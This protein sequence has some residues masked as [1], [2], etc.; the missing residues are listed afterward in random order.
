MS[1][2]CVMPV[3]DERVIG[4]NSKLVDLLERFKQ[5]LCAIRVC[6]LLSSDVRGCSV[7]RWSYSSPGV[8]CS[9][10]PQCILQ[11]G[12]DARRVG[13]EDNLGVPIKLYRTWFQPVE[14][15]LDVRKLIGLPGSKVLLFLATSVSTG[16]SPHEA[17]FVLS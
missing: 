5:F 15:L 17:P 1:F 10:V 4:R 8:N 6:V 2:S 16:P 14:K 3:N 12:C 13:Q 11:G 9:A 7:Y